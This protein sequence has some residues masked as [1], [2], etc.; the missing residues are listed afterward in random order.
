[1]YT[2][3]KMG[4]FCVEMLKFLF[5]ERGRRVEIS[6]FAQILLKL[7]AKHREISNLSPNFSKTGVIQCRL[8]KKRG[9]LGDNSFKYRGHWVYS[10]SEKGGSINR[11]MTSANIGECPLPQ[12]DQNILMKCCIHFVKS[13]VFIHPDGDVPVIAS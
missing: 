7:G 2:V 4:Q 12:M 3:Q 13:S 6:N 1:M 11:N 5:K 9:S 10:L 8:Q